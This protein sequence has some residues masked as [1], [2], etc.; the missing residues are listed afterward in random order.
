[1]GGNDQFWRLHFDPTHPDNP[2]F[3]L[4]HRPVFSRLAHYVEAVQYLGNLFGPPAVG[5]GYP[6]SGFPGPQDGGSAG[7]TVL[8]ALAPQTDAIFGGAK[9]AWD[10]ERIGRPGNRGNR[11]AGQTDLAQAAL[12]RDATGELKF[13]GA[14]VA[15]GQ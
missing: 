13:A 10:G 12:P 3:P 7:Q 5:Q 2:S 6:V 4:D 15:H 8:S 1:M 9:L 11:T 14:G